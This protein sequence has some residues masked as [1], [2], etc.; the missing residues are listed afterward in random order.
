MQNPLVVGRD[1]A[2]PARRAVVV[3]AD[4]GW[5]CSVNAAPHWPAALGARVHI[6]GHGY[7]T[8]VRFDANFL[9]GPW[10]KR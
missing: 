10:R 4:V 9:S 2:A 6:D 3:A 1:D 7:G 8:Y 5:P